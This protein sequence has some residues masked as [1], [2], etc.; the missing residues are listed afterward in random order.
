VGDD[1]DYSSNLLAMLDAIPEQWVILWIEDRVLSA[2]VDTARIAG[3]VD[4]AQSQGAV[5]LK[6]L[7]NHPF[8]L[9]ASGSSEVGEIPITS[10]YRACITVGLWQ[11]QALLGLLRRGETAWE[12]ERRGSRRSERLKGKFLALTLPCRRDPPLSDVHLIIKGRL[13]R[14]AR[15]FVAREGFGGSL[16]RRSIQTL[17]SYGYVRMYLAWLD[18]GALLAWH[19]HR[20]RRALG[21]GDRPPG[22]SAA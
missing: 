18:L 12:L 7:T 3:L 19:G 21:L 9:P 11:K 22:P 16:S 15:S 10:R 17:R 2:P 1:I 14:D 5:Y 4:R 6:L 13:C 8:A 20:V